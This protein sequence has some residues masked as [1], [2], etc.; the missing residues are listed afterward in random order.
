M[1][2]VSVTP[3]PASPHGN[4]GIMGSVTWSIHRGERADLAAILRERGALDAEVV[5]VLFARICDAVGTKVHGDL[6][7]SRVFVWSAR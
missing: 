4:R 1:T 6:E 3:F 5:R 7:P 2:R